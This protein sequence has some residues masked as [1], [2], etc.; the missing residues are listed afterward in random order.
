MNDTI[1]KVLVKMLKDS[2]RFAESSLPREEAKTKSLQ[3]KNAA[4]FTLK[5]YLIGT[6]DWDRDDLEGNLEE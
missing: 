6:G 2:D 4:Y 1:I 5:G 3:A